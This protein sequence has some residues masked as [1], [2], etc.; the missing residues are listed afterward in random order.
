MKEMSE[1]PKVK[2]E[3]AKVKNEV[4]KLKN[5]QKIISEKLGRVDCGMYFRVFK[6]FISNLYIFIGSGRSK[7]CLVV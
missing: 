3:L 2:E 6:N 7:N 1:L 5:D 4:K